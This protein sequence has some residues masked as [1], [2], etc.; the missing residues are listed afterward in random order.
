MPNFPTSRRRPWQPEPQKAHEG[1]KIISTFYVSK[2]WRK[3][4]AAFITGFSNHLGTDNP[5]SNSL[6]IECA[7]LQIVSITHTIDH[8]KPINPA[9]A[10]DTK[11]G[12]FGEP[13]DW[14]NLQPLCKHHHA[15]KTG[16]DR[17][18]R[19]KQ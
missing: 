7:R 10:Y 1:R 6:C 12:E 2:E 8:I 14:D 17:W 9:D 19:K 13:L 4:R 16:K 5:H 18:K 3:L 15:F 11:N